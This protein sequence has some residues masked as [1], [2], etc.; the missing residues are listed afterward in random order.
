VGDFLGSRGGECKF[1]PA[2]SL[3]PCRGVASRPTPMRWR[4]SMRLCVGDVV[5]WRAQAIATSS[6]A[7]LQ[8]DSA[9]A[10]TMAAAGRNSRLQR[11]SIL[12]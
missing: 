7:T 12:V 4:L 3:C 11:W 9:S 6:N 5:K 2:L 8:G 10:A 1:L